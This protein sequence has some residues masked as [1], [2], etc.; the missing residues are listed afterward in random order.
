MPAAPQ[1][2]TLACI[3]L[4]T[5]EPLTIGKLY[6][7]KGEGRG[8]GLAG[9][10]YIYVW[11]EVLGD[12]V[13]VRGMGIIGYVLTELGTFVW[14]IVYFFYLQIHVGTFRYNCSL[15]SLVLI[16]YTRYDHH[17]MSER[18]EINPQRYRQSFNED[19]GLILRLTTQKF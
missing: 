8:A 7:L 6:M 16:I 15:Y 13:C 4:N 17:G 14:S 2:V 5:C 3:S 12:R 10:S 11:M 19:L 9:G 18:F 1:P